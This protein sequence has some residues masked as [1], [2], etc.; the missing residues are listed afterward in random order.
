MPAIQFGGLSS[1]LQTTQIIDALMGAERLGLT[2]LQNNHK[3]FDTR[4]T[5]Y[6]KL[7]T[8]L[9]D[10][11]AKAKA[12]T[13]SGAGAGR[14]A[15]SSDLAALTATASSGAAAGL[16]RISIDR[17]AT[18]TRA[19]S[20]SAVGAAITDA[21]A[22]GMMATLPL[23]GSVSAGTVGIV[24]DG[25]IVH[26]TIGP[27]ATTSL[28]DTLGAIAT[29]VQAQLQGSDPGATVT[30]S[31]VNDRVQLAVSGGSGTHAIHFG[32]GADT[33]N[34]LT[35]FGLAG[36][37][38]AAFG[39]GTPIT[40]STA[41]GVVRTTGALDAAGLTGLASTTTGSLT[42][43]GVAI[44]YDTTTDSLN[45]I[46][47]R[48]NASNAGVTATV[49]RADDQIVLTSKTAGS[50]VIEIADTAGTLGA[51]LHLGPGTTNAQVIGTTA[52]ITV[53]GVVHTSDTNHVTTAIQGVAIDLF[54]EGTGTKTLTVGV[55]RTAVKTAI[56]D[57][58]TSFNALADLLDTQTARP[59]TT[60][61]TAGPLAGE[62][63]LSSLQLS[64]RSLI[65]RGASGFTG[66]LSSFADLG[67]TSGPI[68]SAV[69][70]TDRLQLDEDK[71]AKAIDLDPTR[72]GDLL[73]GMTGIVKPMVDRLTAL[74]GTNGLIDARTKGLASSI[75]LITEQERAY[76]DRL[77][78]KQTALEAKF[79]RLEATL[80]RLQST[81][82]Q[83]A[84]QSSANTNS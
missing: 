64:L 12:F 52:Q 74:T 78:L 22:T 79:A 73:G 70:T 38:A 27:A 68:G 48:I 9:A 43:N 67:V 36:T 77:D 58:V 49:D 51:A 21:T 61:G 45:T 6:A 23:P 60:G 31:I 18:S 35:I 56:K 20:T 16:Y 55:D 40:G 37:N 2:R 72:V 7:G 76:Q 83:L 57:F 63:G 1:G 15:V 3:L 82:S 53:D 69:G 46:L 4:T 65:T 26:A 47:S 75:R 24:V 33:S 42:I 62:E 13:V 54:A 41:L 84:A 71:L 50:R 66:A 59:T 25:Q 8:A 5:A 34:A 14:S 44:A 17:L 10:L 28:A 30:A 19:T 39:T 32:S 80:S 29:A 11:L 81:S